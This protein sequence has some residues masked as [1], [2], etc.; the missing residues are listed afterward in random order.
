MRV[1]SL[2]LNRQRSTRTK[3]GPVIVPPCPIVIRPFMD[4]FRKVNTTWIAGT[5]AETAHG[6]V[7]LSGVATLVAVTDTAMDI[8][9]RC[10]TFQNDAVIV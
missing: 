7:D 2:R 10:P 4:G 1:W 8:H 9:S 3:R 6:H 5:C